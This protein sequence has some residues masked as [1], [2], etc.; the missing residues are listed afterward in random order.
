MSVESND[1][2]RG[3]V[4]LML[5]CALLWPAFAGTAYPG[6]HPATSPA[7]TVMARTIIQNTGSMIHSRATPF[8]TD[9][10]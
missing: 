6:P 4:R 5:A 1:L 10:A 3:A 8:L 9:S 7:L 2:L